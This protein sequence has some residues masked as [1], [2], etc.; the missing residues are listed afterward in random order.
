M[1]NYG[2]NEQPADVNISNTSN[3]KLLWVIWVKYLISII[4]N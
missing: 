1:E 4:K 3:V 2:S